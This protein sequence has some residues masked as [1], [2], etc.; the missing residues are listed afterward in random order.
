MKRLHSLIL[1]LLVQFAAQFGHAA[2][3][4]THVVFAEMWLNAHEIYDPASRSEFIVGTLFPDI[5]YLGTIDRDETHE[6]KI[7]PDKIRKADTFFRGGMRL[8]VFVD[9]QREKFISKYRVNSHLKAIP[10]DLRVLF[11]KVLEDEILWNDCEWQ[12][13]TEMLQVIYPEQ[14]L[15]VEEDIAQEWHQKMSLSLSQKPSLFFQYL[16]ENDLGFLKADAKTI[17]LWAEI[18][19]EYANDPYF[20]KYT[21][22]L[23]EHLFSLF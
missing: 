17:K 8:H 4:A 2:A 19:P 3:P 11:L 6:T 22:D 20:I 18:F 1:L 21:K 9:V 12:T 13:I 15:Y 7:T 16:A 23:K 5:R 10:K 14:L